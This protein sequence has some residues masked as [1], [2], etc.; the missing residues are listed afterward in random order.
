MPLNIVHVSKIVPSGFKETIFNS[1]KERTKFSFVKFL[2][3]S[4][5]SLIAPKG[6]VIAC[7][8]LLPASV[9]TS[10]G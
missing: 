4:V 6:L 7:S 1:P 10:S 2:V 9:L 3:P 5:L 8:T